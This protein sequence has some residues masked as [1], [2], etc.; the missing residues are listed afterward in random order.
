MGGTIDVGGLAACG[1]V[2][3]ASTEDPAVKAGA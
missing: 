2:M 1:V 3:E